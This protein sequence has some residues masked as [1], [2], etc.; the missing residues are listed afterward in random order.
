MDAV[1]HRILCFG[2]AL[3][4]PGPVSVANVMLLAACHRHRLLWSSCLR[5]T[6][7]CSYPCVLSKIAHREQQ[8]QLTSERMQRLEDAN[9]R[10]NEQL[11]NAQEQLLGLQHTE[12]GSEQTVQSLTR[13]LEESGHKCER[14]LQVTPLCPHA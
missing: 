12:R 9:H 2:D 1:G 5:S 14:I 8:L 6:V 13:E 4:V 3:R 7:S 11:R 10:L